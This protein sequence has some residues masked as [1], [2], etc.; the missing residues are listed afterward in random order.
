MRVSAGQAS[1][2]S[3]IC[4]ALCRVTGVP[5]LGQCG[6]PTRAQSRRR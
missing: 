2:A 3:V 5:S 1:T 6:M 4:A